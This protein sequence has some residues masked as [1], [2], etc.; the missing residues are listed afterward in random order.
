MYGSLHGSGGPPRS[1]R[2]TETL[3]SAC[4]RAGTQPLPDR[5]GKFHKELP[6][7]LSE[8]RATPHWPAPG[9]TRQPGQGEQQY[10]IIGG[11]GGSG[12]TPTPTQG[13][14]TYPPTCGALQ[15]VVTG[16]ITQGKVDDPS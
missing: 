8:G 7:P 3:V 2:L 15:A 4:V 5:Y 16:G 9:Y 14:R 1:V 10:P 11:G 12:M 13:G 6:D